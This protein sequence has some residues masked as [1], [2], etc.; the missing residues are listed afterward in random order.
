MPVGMSLARAGK[1]DGFAIDE[2]FA[3]IGLMEPGHDLDQGG[4]AGAIFAE[5]CVNLAG[6]HVERDAVEDRYAGK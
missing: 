1:F 4:F 5:K 3:L 6:A 2:N